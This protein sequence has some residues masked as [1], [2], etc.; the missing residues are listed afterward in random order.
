[1]AVTAEMFHHDGWFALGLHPGEK[2]DWVSDDPDDRQ[3]P[4]YFLWDAEQLEA[5]IHDFGG[6]E[7]LDVS[8]I[9][10]EWLTALDDLDLPLVDIPAA[11][12]SNASISDVLR[13]VRKTYPSRYSAA[14]V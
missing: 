12:L 9:T 1:M 14:S 10:D 4:F 2:R 6:I 7:V 13:W 8:L 11:Q 5:N 3:W